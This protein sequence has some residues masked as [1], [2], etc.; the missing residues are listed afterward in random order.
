ML[1]LVCFI[2]KYLWVDRLRLPSLFR[3]ECIGRS[4]VDL[5]IQ[6]L[7]SVPTG[8]DDFRTVHQAQP[9]V[10]PF[11]SIVQYGLCEFRFVNFTDGLE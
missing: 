1:E 2:E 7:V 8:S 10:L 5:C 3:E 6:V 4:P 9:Y 11:G